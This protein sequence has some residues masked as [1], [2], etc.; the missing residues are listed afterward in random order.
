LVIRKNVFWLISSPC[1]SACI[2]LR[3]S[4]YFVSTIPRREAYT[5]PKGVITMASPARKMTDIPSDKITAAEQKRIA[6]LAYAYWEARGR[7]DG[8]SEEDWFRAEAEIRRRKSA[9][10]KAKN[11]SRVPRTQSSSARRKKAG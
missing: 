8:S 4:V 2:V 11:R 3:R 6:R 10:E 1:A 5:H 9:Y 7:P